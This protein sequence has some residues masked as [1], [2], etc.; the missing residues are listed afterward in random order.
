MAPEKEI[1]TP[2][3][4]RA[5]Q[6]TLYRKAKENARWRAW[7]LYGDLCRQDVLATALAA[8]V[9]NAG[10]PGVDGVTT[11]AIAAQRTSS[12]PSCK[13]SCA[14]RATGLSRC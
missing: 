10:A 6:R 13:R 3:K 14:G 1:I 11:E 12:S 4:V 7:S 8:V 5:L 2:D 9:R